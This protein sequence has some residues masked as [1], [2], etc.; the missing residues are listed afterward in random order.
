MPFNDVWSL[1]QS[2]MHMYKIM[3]Q[4]LV[5]LF[6]GLPL[7]ALKIPQS[8]ALCYHTCILIE[9][10]ENNFCNCIATDLRILFMGSAHRY[11][12]S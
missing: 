5:T 7:Y 11:L 8:R 9:E 10:V 4:V 2:C 6:N 1:F 3:L 12:N